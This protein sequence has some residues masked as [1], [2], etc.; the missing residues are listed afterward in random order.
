MTVGVFSVLFTV[1]FLVPRRVTD[2]EEVLHN[3]TNNNQMNNKSKR[4]DK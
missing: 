1:V 3:Q 2:T 4:T